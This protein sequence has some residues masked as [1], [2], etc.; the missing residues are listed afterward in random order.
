M[1]I[2]NGL[3]V[4]SPA[5][6]LDISKF[7]I[8]LERVFGE[9]D[10]AMFQLRLKGVSNEEIAWLARQMKPICERF[11]IP[12]ILN[13]NPIIAKELDLDGVHIGERDAGLMVCRDILGKDKIIGVSCYNSVESAYKLAKLGADYVSFGA[14]Y[15][16]ETKIVKSYCDVSVIKNFRVLDQKTPVCVIGG[17]KLENMVHLIDGGASLVAISSGIWGGYCV[18]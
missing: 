17:I 12:F 11:R 5:Q 1:N 8:I 3:Y 7:L 13:D 2:P 16:T 4:I 10:V 14:L 6:I 9:H 15:P 18:R